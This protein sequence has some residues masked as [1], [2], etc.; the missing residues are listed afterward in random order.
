[1]RKEPMITGA[2]AERGEQQEHEAN[3]ASSP[4]PSMVDPIESRSDDRGEVADQ[5]EERLLPDYFYFHPSLPCQDVHCP[6]Q[7]STPCR[8]RAYLAWVKHSRMLV[9]KLAATL[10]VVHNYDVGRT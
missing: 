8:L 5:D 9:D 1:M 7:L 4:S 2:D 6:D 10:A 3:Y